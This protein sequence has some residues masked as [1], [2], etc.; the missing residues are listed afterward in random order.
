MRSTNLSRVTSRVA[1][2][3]AIGVAL[4]GPA[5]AQPCNP[6]VDGTYCAE[7]GVRPRPDTSLGSTSRQGIDLDWAFKS[8][9]GD[10]A[11][12]LGA[13]TFGSD[14][15]RCIGLIRRVNCGQ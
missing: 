2:A 15:S 1:G 7:N 10:S 13:I 14:G 3:A 9:T 6:A 4:F 5:T 8:S 11:G 12:T